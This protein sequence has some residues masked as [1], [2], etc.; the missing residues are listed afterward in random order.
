MDLRPGA[1][2]SGERM[3]A[4]G[5]RSALLDVAKA[6]VKEVGPDAVTMGLVADRARV[7]RALVYKHFDNSDDLLQALY[8]R[9]ARGL[10]HHIRAVVEAAPD[11]FEPKLRAFIGATLDA[12]EEHG[13]FFTPLR[14]AGARG[15]ERQGQRDRDRVTVGY[16]AERAAHDFGIDIRTAR[17]VIAVLFTG[18]RSLLSQMR[19]QPGAA[20][21]EFLLHTY[22]EM[23]VG[24]L[25]RLAAQP[26]TG[27]PRTK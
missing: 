26:A 8:K 20:Q 4:D 11:G 6:L 19:S 25:D 24:A 1:L 14:E 10:D 5:R 13:P 21:R 22:V 3:S 12:V 23:T 16:F 2:D 18:I 9:E 15:P 17:S 7:T 27:P